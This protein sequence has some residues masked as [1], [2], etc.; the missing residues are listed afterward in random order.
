[1]TYREEPCDCPAFER[2]DDEDLAEYHARG[3]EPEC[4]PCGHVLDEHLPMNGPCQGTV[5]V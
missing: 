3:E 2:P 4:E 1:M 5:V